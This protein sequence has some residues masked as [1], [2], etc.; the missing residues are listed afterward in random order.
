M[1]HSVRVGCAVFV[2]A[3]AV[4]F[5]A[6]A[7]THR[8]AVPPLP[9]AGEGWDDELRLLHIPGLTSL[10]ENRSPPCHSERSEESRTE[11]TSL[12][13]FL[14]ALRLRSGQALRLLGMTRNVCFHT[15]SNALGQ[16]IPPLPGL[17]R[18]WPNVFQQTA[19]VAGLLPKQ[20]PAWCLALPGPACAPSFRRSLF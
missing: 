11:S 16:L 17:G 6:K 1:I 19:T 15:D 12:T 2:T 4:R 14:V 18:T 7:L 9:Q 8:F 5:L 13:R 20:I 10:C 3:E